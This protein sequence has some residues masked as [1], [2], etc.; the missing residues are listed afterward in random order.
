L[1]RLGKNC[2]SDAEFVSLET[3]REAGQQFKHCACVATEHGHL[4]VQ[5]SLREPDAASSGNSHE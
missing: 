1:P 2:N 3:A 5:P 4:L